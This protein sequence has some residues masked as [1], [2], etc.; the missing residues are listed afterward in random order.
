[1]NVRATCFAVT[2]W[3]LCLAG[4]SDDSDSPGKDTGVQKDTSVGKDAALK[5]DA[6]AGVDQ[7]SAAD[8]GQVAI[9]WPAKADDYTAEKVSYIASLAIPKLD[10]QNTPLCCFDFG[11]ISKDAIQNK[12]NK[13]DNA[14]SQIEAT[15]KPMGM[16]ML[17][18]LESALLNGWIVSLLDHRQL[19]KAGGKFVLAQLLGKYQTGTTYWQAKQGTGKFLIR[20]DSFVG[21]SGTP[22]SLFNPAAIQGDKMSAGPSNYVQAIPFGAFL[23][24]LTV[25]SG[26]I[27]GTASVGA[28]GVSYTD[29]TLSGY[30]KVDDVMGGYNLTVKENCSCLGLKGEL[31]SKGSTG[32]WTGNCVKNAAAL[33]TTAEN[34]ICASFAGDSVINQQLCKV[35][36][37]LIAGAADIDLD[38]KTSTFEA[39]SLGFT[40]TGAQA[41][42][43]GIEP[44]S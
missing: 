17:P 4:C 24:E 13:I 19:P 35:L 20:R 12:T 22:S 29:G 44:K 16:S 2:I 15:L 5:G 41:T 9:K 14:L 42:V 32:T 39:L 34:K 36:P 11:A 43:D 10:T 37:G 27:A 8:A 6:L 26:R 7:S 31:F 40:W 23:Q 25:Y 38:G 33:C 3:S 28:G 21:T 30:V 18:V 1:M